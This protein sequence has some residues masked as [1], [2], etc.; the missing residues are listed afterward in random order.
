MILTGYGTTIDYYSELHENLL[1]V[2][3]NLLHLV[4]LSVTLLVSHHHPVLLLLLLLVAGDLPEL[5]PHH[6]HHHSQVHN[7]QRLQ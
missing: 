1:G 2:V 4:H 3:E 7:H 6:D 5:S